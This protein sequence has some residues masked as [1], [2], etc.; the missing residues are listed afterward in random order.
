MDERVGLKQEYLV[1]GC[2]SQVSFIFP[3]FSFHHLYEHVKKKK[4][5]SFTRQPVLRTKL[6]SDN[7]VNIKSNTKFS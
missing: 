5:V 1:R 2:G 4:S 7:K 3:M 6:L